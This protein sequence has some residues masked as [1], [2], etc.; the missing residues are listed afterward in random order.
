MV[1]AQSWEGLGRD[2]DERKRITRTADGGLWVMRTPGPEDLIA[3]A[4]TTRTLESAR[5]LL[6]PAFGDEGTSRIQHAWMADPGIIRQM[7]TGQACYIHRGTA[8]YVQVARP[9]PS[10]LP[11]PAPRRPAPPPAPPPTA[12]RRDRPPALLD[13]VLGP[14]AAP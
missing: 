14:G 11:L 1:S 12:G 6:G 4:G 5:K 2:D 10:P 13:D 9:R 8:V 7:D 3:N